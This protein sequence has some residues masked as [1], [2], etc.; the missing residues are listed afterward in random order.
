FAGRFAR[1]IRSLVRLSHPSIVK[2]T[3]A[4]QHLGLP[5]AVLQYLPGGS[6][7]DRFQG[8]AERGAPRDAGA[9][10]GWLPAIASAL[11]YIHSQGYI[12][13][14]V[15]AGNILFDAQGHA[16]LG[17][18]GVIKALAAG[19]T[20]RPKTVTNNGMVLGTPEYMAPEL[21]MARPVDGRVDQYALA[22]T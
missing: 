11:D 9:V 3:D 18:F 13:R 7:E 15:K 12:H 22:V 4:G 20:A 6:L 5:F 19:E 14:D 10:T 1:E 21:I 8:A 16:F 2:V 17:D